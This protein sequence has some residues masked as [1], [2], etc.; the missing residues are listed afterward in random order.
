MKLQTL[1]VIF[2]LILLPITMVVSSYINTEINSITT[3]TMYDTRLTNATYDAIKSFQ[4]NEQ[5]SN[6]SDVTKE[7][8]RNVEASINSFYSSLSAGMGVSGYTEDDLKDY[9]PC[10]LYGLYD[11]YYIYTSY[12]DSVSNEKTH[13][14]KPYVYYT[15]ELNSGNG[16]YTIT[17][18]LDNY[19]T[20]IGKD[21]ENNTITKS[22]YLC[23][24][25]NL[26]ISEENLTEEIV[27][28]NE[29][30]YSVPYVYK[31]FDGTKNIK[32]YYVN[33]TWYSYGTAG[34][35]IEEKN[36]ER[37]KE[38]NER[39]KNNNV[40]EDNSAQ[41]YVSDN[42]EFTKWVSDTFGNSYKWL[43]ISKDNN[44]DKK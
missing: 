23:L 34:K 3:Q 17:Y 35:L 27:L 36:N 11:G 29:I 38:L 30:I 19:I 16:Q 18:T 13:G 4:L 37:I 10:L 12:S 33:G 1:T 14:L 21:N 24:D 7:K 15:E 28:D 25:D 40:I 41:N 20:I 2:I 44:P 32:Y 9:I 6:D 5:N 42:S 8:M 26:S 43:K 39:I 22:G 31:K